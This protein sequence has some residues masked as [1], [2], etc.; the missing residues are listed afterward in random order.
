MNDHEQ[1]YGQEATEAAHGRVPMP[2]QSVPDDNAIFRD[3][4][5]QLSS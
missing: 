1:S 3:A 4:V 5:E 2:A